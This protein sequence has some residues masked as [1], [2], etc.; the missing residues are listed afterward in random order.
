MKMNGKTIL[1]NNFLILYQ[2]LEHAITEYLDYGRLHGNTGRI[3]AYLA[4]TL[5]TLIDFSD[6]FWGDDEEIIKAFKYANNTLKH[7]CSLVSHKKITGGL[8]FPIHFPLEVS[9]I[10]VV[11]NFD[12]L[13][14]VN[15][16]A[17][18]EAF[19]RLLAGQEILKTLEPLVRRISDEI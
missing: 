10:A 15:S 13:V 19:K 8:C 5:H 16:K 17:Q 12:N 4:A 14:K 2:E 18:Q 11:W 7:D 6:R 1:G 9:E 3:D